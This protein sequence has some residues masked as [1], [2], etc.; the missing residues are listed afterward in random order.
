MTRRRPPLSTRTGR[1]LP[2]RSPRRPP[3]TAPPRHAARSRRRAWTRPQRRP[4]GGVSCSVMA[5]ANWAAW[6]RA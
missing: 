5:R 4:A 1:V 3:T 6:R 2:P